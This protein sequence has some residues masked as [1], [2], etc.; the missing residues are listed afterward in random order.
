MYV[1]STKA[2]AGVSTV[3]SPTASSLSG[4]PGLAADGS[5][6]DFY[7]IQSGSNGSSYDILYTLDQGKTS[8]TIN[9]FSYSSGSGLWVSNGSYTFTPNGEAMIAEND[10]NG[11]AYLY[12]TTGSGLANNSLVQLDDTAGYNATININTVNNATLYTLTDSSTLKGLDFVP[13]ASAPVVTSISP[14][15][16]PLGGG[17]SVTITG[18]G[19]TDA[20]AVNFGGTA[21]ASFTINSYTSITAVSPAESAG[22]V[23]I[24]VT[25][26]DGTSATSSADQFSYVAAPTVTGISPTSGPL[27]GGTSVTITGS[28]FTG[29]TAVNFGGTAATSFTIDSDTSITA[30]SP[31]E[32]AGTVDITVTSADGTSATSGAD[33]FSYVAAP[34]VTGI[35]PTS[36][37]LGG[38]TSVAITGSGFTGATAVN[39]GSTAATSFTINSDTSIT[40]VSPAGSAGTVDITVTTTG[41]TSATGSADQF[42]Y[43][44]PTAFTPGDIAVVDL[45]V[46]GSKNTTA[47]VLELNPTTTNQTSPVQI[48]DIASTGTDAMHFSDSGT[49]SFLS[50]TND[51]TLLTFAAYN[52]TDDTTSDLASTTTSDRAVG[53]LDGNANFTLQTTY[54]GSSGNQTRSAT[55]LNDSDFYITD[56]GGLYTN[57]ATSPSLSTNIL[58]ARSFDGTVYVSSTKAAA[59]VSTVSSPTDTSLSGLPGLAADGNIQDFYLI[60]SGSNGSSYDILYTLDQN[61]SDATIN[62]Y[63]LVSGTWEANGSYS[64]A[65]NGTA[66]I[67]ANNGSGGASLYVVTTAQA[68]DN[69][70]VQLTDTAGYNAT[71]DIT[72]APVTLYTA[73]G[74]DTLKGLDFVPMASAPVVTSISPT[75]GPLGGGTSVTIT[76][77]G[78]TGATAVNFG[79]NAGTNLNVVSDT[80]ITVTSPSGSGQVDVT[81]VGP[82]GTSATS[83]ADQFTYLAAPTVTG[84]SPTSGPEAGGTSVTITGSGFTGATAVDF[85]GTAATSFTIDSDTSITA[86]SPAE[87]AGTVDITV[88]SADGT[89]ATSSADQFSY[90]A[91]PTVTG[92][93]PTS[94]PLGGGTSVAITGSGLHGCHGGQFWQHG[95]DQLHDQLRHQHHRGQPGR[96]RRHRGHHRDHHRRHLR[97][98]QHRSVHLCRANG[99]HAGRHRCGGPCCCRFEK[100]HCLGPGTQ[101]DHYQPDESRP[102]HRHC[103]D[104]DRCDALQ[105]LGD[106]QF[107]F[108][109]QRRNASDVRRLQHDGRHH[110]GPREHHNQ[111]SCRRNVGWQRELHPTDHLHGVQR[112]SNPFRDEPERLGFLHHG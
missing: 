10:G 57:D 12:V 80:E 74:T 98:R 96:V 81:V 92:I 24:T 27:G 45:A 75:S 94:G 47:S 82:G 35:S 17:T 111:R 40:A 84:I 79:G 5:I 61:A 46:A 101:S 13:M 28:G 34:T 72:A 99:V 37:P 38:G 48:I 95:G 106:E 64:L 15:S 86:V 107:S 60:Q 43:A 77:T 112:Q 31:A 1:S 62:K 91:A 70:L 67:A 69:S 56:K 55:S 19:F 68:V 88:T 110:F 76:G 16:G 54:T 39:F 108:S 41:G 87:S 59:S 52:T 6:Q 97:H 105:R 14:T 103:L 8:A 25:S 20:T 26:A 102:D 9:K 65:D 104:G 89:S 21:A 49:S 11:G 73:I 85:G 53:T 33:Q 100:H 83:S 71:I 36:G 32:S 3:S 93:S 51:G 18:T 58:E 78:F 7:L 4:L 42:T 66:M 2:A 22:T 23:D 109:H 30:V 44:A 50:L 29:A 90:V 63:S